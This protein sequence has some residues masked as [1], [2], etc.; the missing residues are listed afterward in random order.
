MRGLNLQDGK[1]IDVDSV[2]DLVG[3]KLDNP[4]FSSTTLGDTLPSFADNMDTVMYIDV[5]AGTPAMYIDSI[6]AIPGEGELLL[7]KGLDMEI[8]S[9][10]QDAA[11]KWHIHAKIVTP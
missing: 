9:A 3:M 11:G 2:D 8:V 5:P 10:V 4:S 6:S 1:W 7:G